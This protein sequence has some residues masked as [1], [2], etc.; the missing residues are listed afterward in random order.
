METL[1]R[2]FQ[3]IYD[4]MDA[5][6]TF[7]VKALASMKQTVDALIDRGREVEG[8]HRPRRGPGAGLA[9]GAG[10][11]AADGGLMAGDLTRDSDRLLEESRSLLRDNRAGGR[12]RRDGLDR[13]AARPSSSSSNLMTRIKLI[14]ASL[15][16]DRVRRD[17]RRARASTGSASPGSWSRSCAVVAATF[18]FSNFPKVQVPQAQRPQH[19]RRAPHGRAHRAV[20]RAPAPRAAAAGGD[21]GRPDRRPARRA[22]A[23]ARARRAA[24]PGGGRDAQAG[25]R[26][27]ARDDRRLPQDPRALA[28]ASS[29]PAAR[30]TSSWSKASARSAARSTSV[31][32]QLADG[33]LDDLAI[34]T[35]YLDYRYGAAGEPEALPAPDPLEQLNR[36]PDETSRSPDG[37]RHSPQSR[38]R[39]GAP[40]AASRSHKIADGIPGGMAAG[41]DRAGR[42]RTA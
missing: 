1:Q 14:G 35:R 42:A 22:R 16:G 5:V 9:V 12:H 6:D 7:K 25:R 17:G 26:D 11:V 41:R 23:A 33:A 27:A 4:T 8:L 38:P 20:A 19:R 32:R 24:P 21:A 18:L 31:T 29:A 15:L 10:T 34:R 2:A 36:L 3:N 30:P 40:A 39:R 37:S 28:Q 13:R